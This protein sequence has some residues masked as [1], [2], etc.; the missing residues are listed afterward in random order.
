[1]YGWGI[2]APKSPNIDAFAENL[3][4]GG[5]WLEPFEGF[6][7]S[8][9]LVGDPQFDFADY[10]EWIGERFPP[11]RFAQLTSKMDPF[12]LYAVGAFIQSLN[13]NPGIEKVLQR[14]GPEAHVYIGTGLGAFSAIHDASLKLDRAQRIWDR[15]WAAPERCAA[16]RAYLGTGDPGELMT[17]GACPVPPDPAQFMDPD[18]REDAQR[19]WNAFWAARSSDL[20][21]Y[22]EEFARIEESSVGGEVEVGK[23]SLIREKERQRSKLQERWGAPNAPWTQVSANVLWNIPNIP[24]SQVSMVGG[25]TGF[26]FAPVGACA[27]FG[28]CLKLA[29]D[30]IRRGDAKAVV[31]GASDPP[32]HP[33][34]VG[35]F[36][37]ARVI[38][39]GDRISTPLTGLRGTHVSGGAVVWI[40][41]ERSFMEE[42]GFQPLGMEPVSVGVSADA[43]HIIT[44]TKP[45]PLTAIR[46]AMEQGGVSASEVVTWDLHATAT[47][48]DFLEVENMRGLLPEEVLVT[49]RKGTFGHGMSAGGG[50]ELTAQY[51]GAERGILFSTPLTRDDLNSEISGIHSAFVYD[52]SCPLPD[53]AAG[54]LSM[55]VGGV[56]AA[57]ISRPL[58]ALD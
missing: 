55:G 38:A 52:S 43:D 35:S 39:A 1:M 13:Q 7:P 34:A 49:A 29:L 15:F 19:A 25:I 18:E 37:A 26:T 40:V 53:G 48:G 57:V 24:A 3:E 41:G 54:K 21:A 17:E 46:S 51:L 30:A 2:V 36:F 23:L 31:V 12:A 8:R 32:P 56:N 6:G 50:W 9:F 4:S 44:P 45:G 10:R 5:S 14:L 42:K 27:T 33:L 58:K 11:N 16:L 28:V 20:G 22:L 47:P